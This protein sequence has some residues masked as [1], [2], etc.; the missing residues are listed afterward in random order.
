MNRTEIGERIKERRLELHLT[1]EQFSELINV[2][3]KFLSDIE[4]G[5]KGFSIET[6]ERL[7]KNLGL[8]A[9]YILFGEKENNSLNKSDFIEFTL[10]KL[11]KTERNYAE[12]ILLTFVKAMKDK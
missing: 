6:L 8:S 1:R 11:N 2:T 12:Q 10:S 7:V 3:P 5:E 9:D 4:T